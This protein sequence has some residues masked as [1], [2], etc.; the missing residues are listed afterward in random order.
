MYFITKEN[1]KLKDD[2]LAAVDDYQ[3][4]QKKLFLCRKRKNLE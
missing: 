4:S 1:E 2:M 3:T